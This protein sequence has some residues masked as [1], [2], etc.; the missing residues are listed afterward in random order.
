MPDGIDLKRIIDLDP[1]TT[2][3]NDDYTIVDSSGGGAKKF[4]LGA[5]LNNLKSDL[6]ET[7][8]VLTLDDQVAI[9]FSKENDG[10]YIYYGTGELRSSS[11]YCT[12]N[13]IDVTLYTSLLYKRIGVT[14]SSTNYSMAFY[15]KDKVYISSE[16]ASFS[17]SAYGYLAQLKQIDVPSNAVYARFTIIKDS[18]TYGDFAVYGYSVLRDTIDGY[19]YEISENSSILA[20]NDN[21]TLDAPVASPGYLV[22][23]TTGATATSS[24]MAAT[25]YVNVSKYAYLSYRRIKTTDNSPT[26]GMAFYDKDKVYISGDR[27]HGSQ[28]SNGYDDALK[29]I[30]VPSNAVYARF[31][32]RRDTETYGDFAVYGKSKVFN[33]IKPYYSSFEKDVIFGNYSSDW[34]EGQG[35]SYSGF[36]SATVYSDM[37]SAWD[38]ILADSK[39]YMTKESIGTS[40][41]NQTMYCYKLIPTRYRNN[42]G[43]S[44]TNNPP[45]FLIV[46]TLHGFEKSA[47]FG[48]YYF[49]RDLVYS[50]DKNP[51][52]NSI[53]TKCAIYIVPVGN[54]WGFNNNERKN[55]NSVD[56]NRN[57]GV[58]SS[59]ETD[60]TSPYYPGAEPFDQPETQAIKGVIDGSSN[61]LFVVDY[62]TNGQYKV[63]TWANVNWMDCPHAII[64]DEYFKRAYIA[65]Q[66]HISEIT[67]NLQIEYNLDTNGDTIG[68]I[69]L[70][71]EGSTMPTIGYY[72]RTQNIMGFTFEGNNGLPSEESSYSATEQKINSELV[73]NW[74]KNLLL[75]Y[76]DASLK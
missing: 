34:Y 41:D 22:R 26:Y 17:Q 10:Y 36:G 31:T 28:S 40:S 42:T 57:W 25:D 14:G 53:R 11:A 68:S 52:L 43:T 47:A 39:G 51:V 29:R 48:T 59:G 19:T 70:G 69:T 35:E 73:G 24:V 74:I 37:I 8:S 76:K 38:S 6:T 12:T 23:A 50:Y 7:D 60:P 66:I 58:D 30:E 62:H 67:E 2:I 18:V 16:R 49:A 32:T 46:P 75:V 27:A 63:S 15:D 45:T 1:E 13:Y 71:A 20:F 5:E 65:G 56:L 33:E 4:A 61:L 72:S 54:P 44:I 9:P 55:Y 64:D 21:I 3:T